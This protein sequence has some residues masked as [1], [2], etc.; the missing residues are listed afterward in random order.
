MSP[1]LSRKYFSPNRAI[2]LSKFYRCDTLFSLLLQRPMNPL[3][4]VT[5]RGLYCFA[6]DFYIDPW[7]AVDCAIITHAHS[8]HARWGSRLY[9]TAE[10]GR[11]ILRARLG[12]NVMIETLVYGQVT[13]RK[14]V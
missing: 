13:T 1:G 3:L 9:I 6:G 2:I 8:D 5:D 7:G 12:E 14:G 11:E 10:P 4:E